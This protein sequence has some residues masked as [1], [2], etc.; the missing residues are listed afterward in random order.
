MR[1]NAVSSAPQNVEPN[2]IEATTAAMPTVGDVRSRRR[3]PSE[4]VDSAAVG[5]MRLRS[6]SSDACSSS[7]RS[8]R[9]PMNSATSANGKTES[10]RL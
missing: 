7:E 10:N 8:R 2:Q 6:A 1:Q 3:M 5:K 4:S 9:L